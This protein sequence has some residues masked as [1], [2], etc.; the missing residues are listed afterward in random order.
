MKDADGASNSLCAEIIVHN[1]LDKDL[2]MT[3]LFDVGDDNCLS[4]QGYDL[5]EAMGG[6]TDV[7]VEWNVI[8]KKQTVRVYS[9]LAN[10]QQ[11]AHVRSH[12]TN[13]F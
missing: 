9:P 12:L 6:N 11:R 2:L 3:Y 13:K 1:K 8:I 5:F 7:E 10:L 4:Y